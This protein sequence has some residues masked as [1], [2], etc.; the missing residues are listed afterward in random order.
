MYSWLDLD[1]EE[2]LTERP[3]ENNDFADLTKYEQMKKASGISLLYN[4]MARLSKTWWMDFNTF[5]M[6]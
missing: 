1:L 3:Y 2:Y 4:R 6:E 5:F